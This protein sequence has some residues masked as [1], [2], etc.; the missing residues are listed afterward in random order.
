MEMKV[1]MIIIIDTDFQVDESHSR[2][3]EFPITG[4]NIG[5]GGLEELQLV[6]IWRLLQLPLQMIQLTRELVCLLEELNEHGDII[7]ALQ[8]QILQLDPM[9]VQRLRLGVHVVALLGTQRLQML[10]DGLQQ[11]IDE[12]AFDLEVEVNKI[13]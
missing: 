8:Y 10:F 5:P 9:L 2:W 6:L 12:L 3:L 7:D 1:E 4:G 11:Q 13:E